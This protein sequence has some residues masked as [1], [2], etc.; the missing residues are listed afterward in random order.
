MKKPPHNNN[1]APWLPAGYVVVNAPPV[2]EEDAWDPEQIKKLEELLTVRGF[3]ACYLVDHRAS[4][5]STILGNKSNVCEAQL[6]MVAS[7][8]QVGGFE[9]LTLS[10]EH[11]HILVRRA[12]N[13]PG[14]VCAIVI[15]RAI[16]NPALTMTVL[17]KLCDTIT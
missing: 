13:A 5:H 10:L 12:P 7:S 17:K 3:E 1:D 4:T 6:A 8:L 11:A 9:H 2:S 16:G 14:K 15:D